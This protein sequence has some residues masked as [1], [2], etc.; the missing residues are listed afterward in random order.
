MSCYTF[1]GTG[2]SSVEINSH[3][4]S[5]ENAINSAQKMQSI[6]RRISIEFKNE[7]KYF[8]QLPVEVPLVYVKITAC[9]NFFMSSALMQS[10]S[11]V[12]M[13]ILTNS[14]LICL[15]TDVGETGAK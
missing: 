9:L 15:V 14:V 2:D 4:F 12:I 6:Q 11:E 8:G 5:V 10:L 3:Q 13:A 7:R 1:Q